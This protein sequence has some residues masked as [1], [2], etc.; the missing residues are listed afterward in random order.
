LDSPTVQVTRRVVDPINT[1]HYK[2]PL[3]ATKAD[4]QD[5]L[6]RAAGLYF[7]DRDRCALWL[8]SSNPRLQH[9]TP[10]EVSI[11][12]AGLSTCVAMLSP[13]K[14]MKRKSGGV[15]L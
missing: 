8:H 10:M 6:R 3:G 11:D 13:P 9:R 7:A 5:I 15:L 12:P 4:L 2:P 14:A 1:A